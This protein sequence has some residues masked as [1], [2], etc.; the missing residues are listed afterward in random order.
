ML[1]AE[2]L[3]ARDVRP[4]AGGDEQPLELEPLAAREAQRG[5]RLEL[6]GRRAE[7]QVDAVLSQRLLDEG[8]R[9][10]VDARQ[11][12]LDRL[13]ERHL[14]ADAGEE[15]CELAADRAAAEHDQRTRHLERLGR[16]DV[17]PVRHLLEPRNRRQCRRGPR[18]DHQPVVR[19]LLPVD[20]HEARL[21]HHRLATDEL[22]A[23]AVEPLDLRGVVALG[24]HVAPGEDGRHVELGRRADPGRPPRG[25]DELRPAQHRLRRHAGP[26]AAL[27]ADEPPL[28][29][30]QL[31]L[32]VETAEG[33]DEML[34]GRPSAEDDD[35]HLDRGR[36][37]AGTPWRR[38][39]GDFLSTITALFIATIAS[40]RQ[41]RRDR[42]DRLREL[43]AGR[44]R[45]PT[46]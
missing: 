17:R 21:R 31:C 37:P 22:A 24:D 20:T 19:K 3:E 26:V 41:H 44:R 35:L 46:P 13:D 4:P 10:G 23:L 6:L 36:W 27:A 5:G 9:L 30:R 38:A 32:A 18:R 42:V 39:A 8:R 45:R 1:E 43:R 25:G 7:T 11:Q 28:D 34:A 33:A 16:L 15:L 2:R 12:P 14:R 40:W 29:Q